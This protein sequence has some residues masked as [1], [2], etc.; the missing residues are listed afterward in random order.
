MH[1]CHTKEDLRASL[2]ELRTSGS[3]GLVPTMGNL[4][5]GHL[6]LVTK[7]REEN[8]YVLASIFVNPTQFGSQE[9]LDNYPKTLETDLEKLRDAGVTGV[10]APSPEE[11]YH[12]EAQT[13]VEAKELASILMGAIRPGHFRGVA[14][15]VTKLFNLFQPDRAYFGEKDY[16]QLAIIRTMVRD[17]DIPVEVRSVPTVREADGLAMSSR[18]VRLSKQSRAAA[19]ILFKACKKAEAAANTG[20]CIEAILEILHDEIS[21]EALADIQSIDIRDAK[22]LAP[23]SGII[24]EAVVILLAVRFAPVLLIDQYSLAPKLS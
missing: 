18:N 21:T 23:V 4:H 7:A 8:D 20:A 22:T 3:I 15:I 13:F 6:A 14:T 17:L 16:Q 12:S 10:F 19:S 9:D 5:D 1:I 24:S 2:S 11:V